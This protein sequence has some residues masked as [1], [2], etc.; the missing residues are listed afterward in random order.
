MKQRVIVLL[1]TIIGL[2]STIETKAQCNIQASICTPGAAGPFTFQNGGYNSF[3]STC[4]DQLTS[5]QYAFIVLY[6]TQSGNLNMLID[7]NATSGFLDVA[8]YNVPSGVAP[9]TA[10]QNSS[11]QIN[12][13]Y[14]DFS[15]GCNQF[16]SG[17]SCNSEVPAV[18]VTAGQTIMIVVED[19]TNGP[20]TS[21]TLELA[22]TPGSA[23]TGSPDATVVS[24]GPFCLTDGPTQLTAVNNGGTWSGPG[25]SASGIFNPQVAGPGV[26]TI[27]YSIGVPPCN[28]S[29]S[30]QITV[31]S[32]EIANM[33][34]SAC[35]GGQYNIT[36]S[37]DLVN[38]PSSGQLIV[39]N[40][41][42]NQSVVASA[43]FS[44]GSYNY[45]M[46]WMPV[47][48]TSCDLHAYFSNGSCSQVLT[49]TVPTCPVGCSFGNITATPSG[50]V[51]GNVFNVNGTLTFVNPPATGQLIVEDCHG[52]I[53]TFN[54]PF[55]SPINY[56]FNSLTPDGQSCSVTA[57]FTDASSCTSNTTYTAPSI[58]IT[59]ASPDVS[60]CGG[61]IETISASGANS[62]SWDNGLGAGVSH[63]V[64]P[65]TTTTYT[66]TGTT[67]G[68]TSTDQVEV[69]INSNITP[70]I[71][72]D[73]TICIGSSATISA[74]GG[75]TYNWDNSL[76]AGNSHTVSPTS[77]TTYNVTVTD[78]NG[79]SGV[80]QT[81]V[82]VIPLPT[83]ISNNVSVC[84]SSTVD[85]TASGANTYIWSP[86]INI[87][88]TIGSTVT[89]TPGVSTTYTITGI[90]AYGCTGTTT[91]DVVVYPDPVI[92]AGSDL[93]ACEGDQI[94][95]SGSGAGIGGSYSWNN[96][97]LNG[98][99]FSPPADTTIYVV[100]GITS[101]GCSNTDSLTVVVDRYPN[102]SFT[103][104]QDQYCNPVVAEFV[105]TSS[106]GI[107]CLWTFDNGQ[108]S[109]NCDTVTQVFT[110][111]G[112]YGASLYLESINGC[113]ATYYQDSLVI[114]DYTP[115]ASFLPNP[116]LFPMSNPTVNFNNSSINATSYFW[117]FGDAGATSTDDSPS[118]VYPG[119]EGDYDVILVAYSDYGCVDTFQYM[120]SAEEDLIFYIPNSFTPDGDS[121]NQTF[122]PVFTS[123]FD[124]QNFELLIFNRWG[125]I[126]FESHD[127]SIGWDG[128]YGGTIC[129]EGTYVWK[130]E[131]KTLKNDERKVF[132]GHVNL[133]R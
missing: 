80:A 6:I 106:S 17:F 109:N 14:A 116:A 69:S 84:E 34:V 11:N 130:I 119:E 133:I 111:P 98:I 64:S 129:K 117:D 27:N 97:V 40:C 12:C 108:T 115:E 3:N 16:G 81:T 23:Q 61:V 2:F 39:E 36:G 59:V 91:V 33:D 75:V 121:F 100:T 56:N 57:Y 101:D 127:A 77:T 123:G 132:T 107:N 122:Q 58:P 105:N 120:V 73:T 53:Q 92:E 10:I 15:D 49:Y 44:S 24:S 5:S 72:A 60:I 7:G 88:P 38:P 13:N 52:N 85:I 20:S 102:I 93:T 32:I 78:A 50:C 124:S 66:V 43:P 1:I 70:T 126:I 30:T 47:N 41:D 31:G 79:C 62:Y 114:V 45:D 95:I 110:S 42:G 46:G 28:A 9:C 83:I 104:S 8:T 63:N 112:Q 99:P 94:V 82:T 90:D 29:S 37:I 35:S 125:E 54:P 128:T 19:Y 25:V 55:V 65:A 71:S 26:H 131:F 74:S 96:N 4:L 21:F 89:F 22:T 48:G 76:G 51:A 103:V 18:A 67:N 68:C 87:T 118:H 86:A 113:S